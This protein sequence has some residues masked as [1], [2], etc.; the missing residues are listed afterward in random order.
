MFNVHPNLSHETET[1]TATCGLGMEQECE[2]QIVPDCQ[3]ELPI[4]DYG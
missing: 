4:A 3:L 2:L 1:E